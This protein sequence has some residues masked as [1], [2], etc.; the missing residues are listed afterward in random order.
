MQIE[1][2]LLFFYCSED[3]FYKLFTHTFSLG[4]LGSLDIVALNT[5]DNHTIPG[6]YK[7]DKTKRIKVE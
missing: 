5:R 4:I 2:I 7:G 1:I 6:Q 3:F